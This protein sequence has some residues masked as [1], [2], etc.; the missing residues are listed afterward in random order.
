MHGS[1]CNLRAARKSD[2]R[3][4]LEIFDCARKYMRA[5]GN[6]TQWP[7]TYPSAE[8]ISEDIDTGSG[9]VITDASG[10]PVATFCLLREPD[11]N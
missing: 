10:R 7:D 3:R 6:L 8:I 2:I 11:P 5:T 4:M 9:M 1:I